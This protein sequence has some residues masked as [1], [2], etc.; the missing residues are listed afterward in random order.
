M[1]VALIVSPYPLEEFPA[2]PL[3]ICYAAAAFEAAGAEVRIFDYLVRCYRSDKLCSELESFQPDIVGTNSVTLNFYEAASI[4][5]TVKRHFPET[6][7]IMGGPHVSFDFHNG[8]HQYPEIDIMVIGE[9]E[10]TIQELIPS[11]RDR[12]NWHRIKGIAFSANGDTVYTGPREFIQD[13]DTLP[14]PARH[15]IPLSRYQALGFPVSIITSRGCPNQCIFCQGRHM[16]GAKVRYRSISRISDEIEEILKYGFTRL[17]IADDFFTFDY[18]RVKAFC[19][20]I[21]NRN[22]EFGWSAFARADYVNKELLETMMDAGCD[23]VLFGIESGNQEILDRIRKRIK[24]DQIRKAVADC[25]AV[26]MKVFGSLIVGLPGE[27]SDTLM[28]TY[29][30]AQELGIDYGYHFLAPF[31]GTTVKENIDHYDLELLTEDWSQFDAN[32]AIVRTSRLSADEI[33]R[34]V[35]DYYTSEVNTEEEKIARRFREGRS[36]DSENLFY[37]GKQ[38]NQI[39]F[40]L[41]SEDIIEEHCVFPAIST[42]GDLRNQLIH[43]IAPILNKEITMVESVIGEIIESGFLKLRKENGKMVWY[44][45]DNNQIDRLPT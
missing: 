5:Q 16:V 30:F 34:F 9:G 27:S 43:K 45:P 23:S 6:V 25:K 20:E 37:R 32:R 28:D 39:I 3:G 24:L 29:R 26:G 41:F 2:P 35:Y 1:K 14:M 12:S 36:S 18:E 11:I 7:T 31:P 10:A 4:L 33:E 19:T 40:K 38:K 8:L 13:L 21:K 22:L 17:N 44:W 15:L 42:G